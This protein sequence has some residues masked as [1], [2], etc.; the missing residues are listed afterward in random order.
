MDLPGVFDTLGPQP[1]QSR[2]VDVNSVGGKGSE[3]A[4]V[5]RQL[6]EQAP[7]AAAEGG[8]LAFQ[9]PGQDAG[10]VGSVAA[11]L[12]VAGVEAD[13]LLDVFV[14][15]GAVVCPVMA[16][17]LIPSLRG[18][19]NGVSGITVCHLRELVLSHE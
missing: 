1:V 19:P 5:H 8:E 9:Y 7:D 4:V 14:F 2:R 17:H 13:R 12:Q 3:H 18:Q 6:E 11:C 16:L 15:G 10:K